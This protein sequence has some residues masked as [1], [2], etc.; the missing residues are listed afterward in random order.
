MFEEI[1]YNARKLA[2]WLTGKTIAGGVARGLAAVGGWYTYVAGG[3]GTLLGVGLAS[4][5]YRHDRQKLLGLYREEIAAYLDKNPKSVDLSDLKTVALGRDGHAAIPALEEEYHKL[6]L[7]RWLKIGV[8]I[9]VAVATLAVVTSI[10]AVAAGPLVIPA[11]MGL[12]AP[13]V[14][15]VAAHGIAAGT[16]LFGL[17]VAAGAVIGLTLG[18]VVGEVAEA[19]TGVNKPGGTRAMLAAAGALKSRG[20]IT[21]TQVMAVFAAANPALAAEI[22]TVHGTKYEDLSADQQRAVVDGIGAALDP[23]GAAAALSQGVIKPQELVFMAAG[24]RS[25]VAEQEPRRSFGERASELADR[26][27]EYWRE[28]G[29]PTLTRGVAAASDALE[30]AQHFAAEKTDIAK[31]VIA[32]KTAAARDAVSQGYARAREFS[33][34]ALAKVTDVARGMVGGVSPAFASSAVAQGA[35]LNATPATDLQQ[36]WRDAIGVGVTNAARNL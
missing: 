15:A 2:A 30:H 35:A 9:A 7:K 26:G 16:A 1:T 21:P 14:A 31:R 32:E 25:G 36:Q 11:L 33:D 18:T 34:D 24:V 5:D 29:R 10:F 22:K 19:A 28:R 3:L 27:R 12:A 17:K 8:G 6:S 13:A 4:M 20:G 23:R